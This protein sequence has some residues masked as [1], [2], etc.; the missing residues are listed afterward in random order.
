MQERLILSSAEARASLS[1]LREAEQDSTEHQDSCG[2][3]FDAFAKSVQ[4][5]LSGKTSRERS[6]QRTGRISDACCKAWMNSGT[7][8]RGEFSTRS[9]S[10][11]PSDAAVSSLSEVLET[12]VPPTYSLSPTACAG[13]LRRAETRGK[14]LPKELKEALESVFLSTRPK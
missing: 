10:E 13:I 3:M 8:W 11:W 5:G 1:V 6:L 12:D 4:D 7:V 2:S 14:A 9:S